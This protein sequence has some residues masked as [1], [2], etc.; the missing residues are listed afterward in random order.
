MAFCGGGLR[1]CGLPFHSQFHVFAVKEEV[2]LAAVLFPV[3][4]PVGASG[5]LCWPLADHH[6]CGRFGRAVRISLGASTF[7]FA[8]VGGKIY[9]F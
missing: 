2:A 3:D 4:D 5:I 1:F 8:R 9:L 6:Y 7:A